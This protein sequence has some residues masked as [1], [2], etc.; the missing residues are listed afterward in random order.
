M[1]EKIRT[2]QYIIKLARTMR[3]NMTAT[4]KILWNELK[5]KKFHGYRFRCQHPVY[6]YVLDFYCHAAALAIEIDGDIHKSRQDYDEF[7]DEFLKQCGITTIRFTNDEII[8]DIKD[9]LEKI[10]QSLEV[11]TN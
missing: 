5:E 9:V 2:P 3:L 11:K 7:R 10:R 4:E 1:K 8:H 6:R